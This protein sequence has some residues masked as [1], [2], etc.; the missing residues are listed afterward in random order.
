VTR[1]ALLLALA[2]AA[3][4]SASAQ[5]LGRLFFT[6][7]ERSALEARRKAGVP[8]KPAAPAAPPAPSVRFDG[9]VKRSDG[10]PTFWIDGE[11]VPS[12]QDAAGLRPGQTLDRDTGEVRDVIGPGEIRVP[13]KAK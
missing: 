1:R 11:A 8:D 6:P 13:R 10:R 12:A 2:L 5:E 9:Y 7:Q 3:A 4:G